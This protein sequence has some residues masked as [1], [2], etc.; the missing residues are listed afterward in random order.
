MRTQCPEVYPLKLQ[1]NNTCPAFASAR[2]TM[3]D[4][5]SRGLSQE[6]KLQFSR[7]DE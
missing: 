5:Q 1:N 6:G 2:T 4:Y 3:V 7:G